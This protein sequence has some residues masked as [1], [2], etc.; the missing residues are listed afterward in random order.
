MENYI[1]KLII[2]QNEVGYTK[3]KINNIA[4]FGL[5]GEAGEVLNEC[6]HK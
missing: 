3:G 4:L 6:K 5:F 2:L 1:E